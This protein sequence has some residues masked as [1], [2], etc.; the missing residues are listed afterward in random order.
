LSVDAEKCFDKFWLEDCVIDIKNQ[1]MREREAAI[2][3]NMNKKAKATVL[4]PC[5]PTREIQA[6]LV[7]KQGTILGPIL[8]CCSTAKKL[9]A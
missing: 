9:T 8:C 6:S 3:Y 2:V 5:G 4:T 7:V 1:G